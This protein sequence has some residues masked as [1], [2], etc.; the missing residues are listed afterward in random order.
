[1]LNT[2]V[3]SSFSKE[4]LLKTKMTSGCTGEARL[5]S[6][7]ALCFC[8]CQQ[9]LWLVWSGSACICL[10]E[11]CHLPLLLEP[12]SAE[13]GGSRRHVA[14]WQGGGGRVSRAIPRVGG[15]ERPPQ[16]PCFGTTAWRR[17]VVPPPAQHHGLN[18]VPSSRDSSDLIS[19]GIQ[20]VSTSGCVGQG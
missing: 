7:P 13:D 8:W 10:R 2:Y 20:P 19:R 1:M 4:K 16:Y 11:Q 17:H 12:C 6:C 14:V 15:M 9:K 18:T 5:Q 3:G